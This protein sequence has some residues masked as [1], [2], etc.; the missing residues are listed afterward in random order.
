MKQITFCLAL[1]SLLSFKALAQD[2]H[3]TAFAKKGSVIETTEYGAEKKE[4]KSTSIATVTS[5]QASGGNVVAE[6]HTIKRQPDNTVTEDKVAKYTCDSQGVQ[7]GM[8]AVD[9]KT[10]K[11]ISVFYPK[12]PTIGQDLKTNIKIAETIKK[13]GKEMDVEIKISNRKVVGSETI[14][15]KAGTW[16]CTKITYDFK[17]SFKVGFIGIPIGAKVTEYYNP[18]VGVVRS[19]VYVKDKLDSYSEITS[20]KWTK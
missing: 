11:D 7:W 10:K 15:V 19:E 12:N 2:C 16:K 18:E 8:G 3:A 1:A 14:K 9:K 6:I 5:S 17:F 20:V 4:L 13:D